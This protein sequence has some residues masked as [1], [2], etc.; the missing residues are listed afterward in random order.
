MEKNTAWAIGLSSV[1]LIGFFFLQTYF[2]PKPQPVTQKNESDSWSE[3]PY[4]ILSMSYYYIGSLPKA[5][6]AAE[7]AL[8]LAP[9]NE[10]IRNNLR[11]FG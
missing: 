4:D 9:D 10:R 3:K 6:E 7:Q 8:E 1:V 2:M 5:R 11:C